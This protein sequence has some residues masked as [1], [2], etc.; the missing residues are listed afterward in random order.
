MFEEH[1]PGQLVGSEEMRPE[2]GLRLQG[3][4][5]G[6]SHDC[7]SPH[8]CH[9]RPHVPDVDCRFNVLPAGLLSVLLTS[10]SFG[11]GSIYSVPLYV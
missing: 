5:G 10:F 9:H 1:L 2:R 8:S 11:D 7:Q 3:H 6:A 4:R